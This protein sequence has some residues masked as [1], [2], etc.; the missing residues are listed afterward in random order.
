MPS[1][2]TDEIKKRALQVPFLTK[3]TGLA[4]FSFDRGFFLVADKHLAVRKNSFSSQKMG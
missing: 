2:Q 1:L 3:Q 4:F